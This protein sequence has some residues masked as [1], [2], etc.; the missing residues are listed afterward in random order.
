M[1]EFGDETSDIG[2]VQ[3][4]DWLY[5]TV[6]KQSQIEPRQY[7]FLHWLPFNSWYILLSFLIYLVLVC[8]LHTVIL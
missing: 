5:K 1:I 6:V 4:D 2:E 7:H 3:S 8:L